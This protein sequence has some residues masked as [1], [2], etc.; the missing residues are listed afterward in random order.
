MTPAWDKRSDDPLSNYGLT[1]V[2]MY[3]TVKGEK[4][5]VTLHSFTNWNLPH[6][7]DE[8]MKSGLVDRINMKVRF[9]PGPHELSC[10]SPVPT[11]EGHTACSS[12]CPFIEGGVCYQDI[13]YSIADEVFDALVSGGSD[14]AWKRLEEIYRDNFEKEAD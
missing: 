6:V 2:E 14:A 5:A 4:G 1:S 13:G 12:E 9:L 3:L 8:R 7:V 10:H 11:Y